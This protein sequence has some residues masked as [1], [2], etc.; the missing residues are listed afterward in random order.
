LYVY[1]ILTFSD[2]DRVKNGG[3]SMTT[4]VRREQMQKNVEEGGVGTSRGR[5]CNA[6]LYGPVADL[7]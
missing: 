1:V 5:G 4:S 7:D 3:I 2:M 6:D